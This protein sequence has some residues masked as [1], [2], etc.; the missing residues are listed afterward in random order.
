MSKKFSIKKLRLRGRAQKRRWSL[1]FDPQPKNVKVTI[2][3]KNEDTI[4]SLEERVKA[5][6]K[7]QQA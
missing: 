3:K 7:E 4:R 2:Q 5:I 1:K 6:A